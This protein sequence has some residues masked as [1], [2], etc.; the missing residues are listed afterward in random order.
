MQT[1]KR[2]GAQGF[3]FTIA[4]LAA[5]LGVPGIAAAQSPTAVELAARPGLQ[6]VSPEDI[7]FMADLYDE[8]I[9]SG[10]TTI[11]FYSANVHVDPNTF[12]GP[13]LREFERNFPGIV[14]QGTR[15]SGAEAIT[16]IEAEFASG[17]RQADLIGRPAEYIEAGYLEPFIPPTARDVDPQFQEPNGYFTVSSRKLFGLAYNT[18]LVSPDQLPT[19]IEELLVP[20]WEGLISI[21]QPSGLTTIDEAI[22]ILIEN[23]SITTETLQKIAD[24]IPQ[25]DRLV[26][27][28]DAVNNLAQGRY[29]FSLWAPNQVAL[30]LA[31]RGAPVAVAPIR[32]GTLNDSS[33][34]L[35]RDAPSPEAA[36][37][38]LTWLFT[39]AAQELTSQVVR[40]YG[41][42]PDVPVPPGL[43]D[44]SNYAYVGLPAV[45]A[46]DIIRGHFEETVRPIFGA[47][48]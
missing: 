6:G 22:A 18:D 43:P 7:Q 12:L 48:N 28:S 33:Q 24:F 41:T 34:G 10:R 21:A 38:L 40:E 39:P 26:R 17:N 19:T 11:N 25:Q 42:I 3:R 46:N 9:E 13:V 1:K 37:L 16:R 15:V 44:L 31:D 29:A 32:E 4:L 8:A 35:L 36:K 47:G 5:G 23:D 27:A 14:V 30:E 2:A 20:E 45:E